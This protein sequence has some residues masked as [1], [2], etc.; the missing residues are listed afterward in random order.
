M[1]AQHMI[2]AELLSRQPAAV[3]CD[4]GDRLADAPPEQVWTVWDEALVYCP[5]CAAHEG[6]GPEDQ[7]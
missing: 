7:G 3:C 6:I 2:A 4:C 1:P 5:L